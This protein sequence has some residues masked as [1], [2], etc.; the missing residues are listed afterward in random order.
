MQV[1]FSPSWTGAFSRITH[2]RIFI[3]KVTLNKSN[4]IEYWAYL[5]ATSWI[6]DLISGPNFDT[7]SLPIFFF[8]FIFLLFVSYLTFHIESSNFSLNFEANISES[9]LFCVFVNQTTTKSVMKLL[10]ITAFMVS[11]INKVSEMNEVHYTVFLNLK[12]RYVEFLRF[13]LRERNKT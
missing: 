8:F 11:N 9:V 13:Y 5:T 2:H 4:F 6:S 10:F 3:L 12:L 7:E 1:L